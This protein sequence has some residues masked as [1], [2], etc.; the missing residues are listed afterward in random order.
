MK[1]LIIEDEY[2]AFDRLSKMIQTLESSVHIV[3]H[4]DS[5]ES[6]VL[7]LNTNP[8]PDLILSDI[9]LADGSSFLIF[10]QVQV[11]CPIVFTTAYDEYALKAF[12][13]NSIDYLLKPI[14]KEELQ[15]ALDKYKNQSA[16]LNLINKTLGSLLA[17]QKTYK[18]RF[19]VKMGDKLISI[20]SS[21]IS[22]FVSEDKYVFLYHKGK[23]YPID[24]TLEELEALLESKQFYKLNRKIIVHFNAI[25]K[26]YNHLNGKL[27][28]E[29]NPQ[30]N[31]EVFVSREKAQEFKSWLDS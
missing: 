7:W 15:R 21:E 2:L 4:L 6:A 9:H 13:V 28:I 11:R 19:L 25:D 24:F 10:D 12:T 27:K 26:I 8:E 16:P 22:Y 3:A 1:I 5:I 14:K 17:P 18:E 31:E 29:L 20:N 23:K 30:L